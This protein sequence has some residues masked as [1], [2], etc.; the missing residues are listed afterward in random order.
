MQ[1]KSKA[2]VSSFGVAAVKAYASAEKA[3]GAYANAVKTSLVDTTKALEGDL[4]KAF[5]AAQEQLRLIG[6][7]EA[8]VEKGLTTGADTMRSFAAPVL[9]IGAAF[10]AATQ[11]PA[12]TGDQAGAGGA[13]GGEITN[14]RVASLD[15]EAATAMVEFTTRI[16]GEEM[17]KTK[18]AA[19]AATDGSQYT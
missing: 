11:T 15:P 4:G 5:I 10:K 3:A 6:K 7:N 2:S 14:V 12:N 8:L 13:G 16:V 19:L 18:E 9:G 1:E 17:T